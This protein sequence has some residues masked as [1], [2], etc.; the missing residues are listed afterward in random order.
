[1]PPFLR[2][3]W[4]GREQYILAHRMI[5]ALAKSMS[6]VL[7]WNMAR[8]ASQLL[9]VLLLARALGPHGYGTFSGLAGL[10]LALGG[11]AAL[12]MGLRLYEHVARDHAVLDNHWS[13]VRAGL[14]WSMPL[15]L[16]LYLACVFAMRIDAAMSV[17]VAIGV[18]EIVLAPLCAQV[19]FA[20]ASVG[21][22]GDSAAAPVVLS[23]A[24]VVA[25]GGYLLITPATGLGGYAVLH[26]AATLV[27]VGWIWRRA[28]L[29]LGL[30]HQS[31]RAD[32]QELRSGLG[33]ASIWASGLALTSLD[34]TAV[35][36]A[37][38]STV[39]G[40]YTA[41]Y[42]LASIAALPVEA[43]TTTIMP[44]LFRAGGGRPLSLRAMLLLIVSVLGY[45]LVAGQLMGLAV[46]L[47][48]LL[49]GDG[50]AG[51]VPLVALLGWWL[52]AYCLRTLLGNILLG[53]GR[54]RARI[55][56]ELSGLVML[57]SLVLFW[58][59]GM[60][61]AGA[62]KALLIAEWWIACVSLMMV[63]W[64]PPGRSAGTGAA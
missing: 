31:R 37:G 11:F 56:A 45:G 44:R 27:A 26:V 3:L 53:H 50:F 46:P 36:Y 12:G 47:V 19:A 30:S 33:F 59:P 34:K 55:I 35:M 25:A 8:L 2:A 14:A 63:A 5:L 20:Y 60:G 13:L 21:R 48:P 1:M 39:A 62:M 22:M 51:L 29:R 52:P 7:A 23:I 24:R 41:G 16:V 10:G 57:G 17:V 28:H 18:A 4:N 32:R 58:V 64:A 9:W 54:K 38:G 40:E 6:A 15:L 61:L 42:R 49:L 43:F